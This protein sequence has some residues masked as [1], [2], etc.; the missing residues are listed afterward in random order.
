[1]HRARGQATVEY[2]A[3]VALVAAVLALAA[4]AASQATGLGERTVAAMRRAL[5]VVTGGGC[6]QAETACVVDSRRQTDSGELSLLVARLGS[7]D[8]LLR[9][10]R[11]DGT[12]ALTLA[13][14][15]S[16]GVDVGLGGDVEIRAGRINT[17]LGAELRAAVLSESGSGD[18]YVVHG[19]RAADDL[20]R[21]LILSVLARRP[22]TSIP[23]P[24]GGLPV[25]THAAPHL[26]APAQ[27]F[28]E[29][30]TAFSLDGIGRAGVRASLHVGAD[31]IA[32]ERVDRRSG[33]RTEYLRE[34][35]GIEAGLGVLGVQPSAAI[36]GDELYAVSLDR[37]GR[38]VDFEVLD[39][40]T[41]GAGVGVPGLVQGAARA[42]GLP[43]PHPRRLEVEQHLDLS[44][45]AN[46]A[47]V[48]D[49]VGGLKAPAA[50]GQAVSAGLR[51]RLEAAGTT[52]VRS[53]STRDSQSGFGGHM[54]AGLRVG[55]H[56]GTDVTTAHLLAAA[57]RGPGGVWG[58]DPACRV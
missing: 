17:G 31:R 19:A 4:V 34:R 23:N 54:A 13:Q 47:A 2:V 44:D 58:A 37:D 39:G 53:Y 26:P 41:I 14:T 43:S 46:L 7:D 30:A 55:G 20:Q 42:I 3:L 16:G 5:C 29:H 15:G 21:R 1:M 22:S 45:P 12:V 18:T 56:V 35:D 6:L 52:R 40:A 38:P 51:A 8:V 48:R 32:G 36:A 49:F 57:A 10:E 28:H 24:E 25:L 33:M 9:E 27:S 11:A 50:L